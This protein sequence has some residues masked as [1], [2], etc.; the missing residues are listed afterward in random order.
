MVCQTINIIHIHNLSNNTLIWV[1]ALNKNRWLMRGNPWTS[2]H[3]CSSPAQT[4]SARKFS[5]PSRNSSFPDKKYHA[6]HAFQWKCP[7][8]NRSPGPSRYRK[9]FTQNSLEL[10]WVKVDY[11]PA[12]VSTAR[13][14]LSRILKSTP[15]DQLSI[16]LRSRFIHSCN[17]TSFRPC[18]CSQGQ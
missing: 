13:G 5:N 6:Q 2:R 16:Y 9:I 11:R 7:P 10:I 12:P 18:T 4:A 1:D 3:S 8:A 15:S 14:V 17:Q